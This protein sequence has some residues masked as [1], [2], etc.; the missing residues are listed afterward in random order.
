MAVFISHP[1]LYML[2]LLAAQM[3]VSGGMEMP[4]HNPKYYGKS[5]TKR[6]AGV[7]SLHVPIISPTSLS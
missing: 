2:L 4:C 3:K 5:R 7:F 1:H 6:D